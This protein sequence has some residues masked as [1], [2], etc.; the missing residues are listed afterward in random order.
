MKAK[1]WKVMTGMKGSLRR[2]L[3][4]FPMVYSSSFKNPVWARE[5]RMSSD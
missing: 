4:V 5:G 1:K 2:R 3:R